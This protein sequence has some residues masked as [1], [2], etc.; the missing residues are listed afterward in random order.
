LDAVISVA[1][2][3][4]STERVDRNE[5]NV[6][7]GGL[8]LIWRMAGTSARGKQTAEEWE[9]PHRAESI[10]A[11]EGGWLK[12]NFGEK[13]GFDLSPAMSMAFVA[14]PDEPPSVGNVGSHHKPALQYLK[15]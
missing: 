14:S 12:R 2:N 11:A 9:D 13:A 15:V 3:V 8:L 1:V 10:T 7:T 6:G 5:K 4:V